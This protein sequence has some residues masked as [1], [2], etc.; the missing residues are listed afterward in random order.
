MGY[1]E[2][3]TCAATFLLLEPLSL[4]AKWH[5]LQISLKPLM[6]GPV[7]TIVDGYGLTTEWCLAKI[8]SHEAAFPPMC[9]MHITSHYMQ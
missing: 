6:L 8:F 9:A 3:Q 5:T 2:S 4:S 7:V 1:H